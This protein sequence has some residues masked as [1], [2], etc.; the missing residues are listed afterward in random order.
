VKQAENTGPRLF[1]R[2][3]MAYVDMPAGAEFCNPSLESVARVRARRPQTLIARLD[4]TS[5]YRMTA[6]NLAGLL[7]QRRPALAR[8]FALARRRRWH[9][10]P[11]TIALNRY[12]DRGAA[13]LL[14][15]ADGIVFQSELSRDMHRAFL[16]YRPGRVPEQVI[17]NGVPL[18]EF[19]PQASAMRLD[20]SPAVLIS[21]SIYR[22]HKRLHSAIRVVNALAPAFPRM[23]LHVLGEFDPLVAAALR[24]EDV[25]RCVFH[26]RVPPEQLPALYRGADLQLSPSLFDPCP[27]VVCEGLASGLPVLTPRQS[28]AAELVGD[29]NAEWIVDERL[30]L[31]YRELHVPEALPEL[32]VGEYAARVEQVLASLP[33]QRARARQRAESALDLARIAARYRD[34]ALACAAGGAARG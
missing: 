34:F 20:G 15:N 26:G 2:R 1:M 9:A 29:E 33:E 21:A 12:L 13:W 31:E 28:G 8:W 16:G 10:R 6:R 5:Y 17:L 27:N 22:L 11:L 32:P 25:S 24:D 3:M 14:Q 4:G 30:P 7:R 19:R 18:D 23:R